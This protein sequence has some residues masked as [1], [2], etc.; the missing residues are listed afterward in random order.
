MSAERISWE[1]AVLDFRARPENAEMARACFYDD[2]LDAAARRYADSSEWKAVRAWLP[3]PPGRALD[4][5]AGRGISSHA[6]ARDGWTVTALEPDPSDVVGA[7]AIRAL[8]ERT[9]LAIRV[10]QQPA[11]SLPFE[12]ASFELVHCRAVLHHAADLRRLCADAA[13]VLVPGGRF[14]ALREH[15]ISR[16][17]DL[18][19]FLDSHPL[20]H[21]YG[22]EHAYLLDE[23]T[24][25]IQAA[26]LRLLR[27]VNPWQ[28]DAN[29]FP[30]TVEDV[31][32][33]LASRVHLPWPGLIPRAAVTWAGARLDAPGRLYSFVAEKPRG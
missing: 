12:D 29:T 17:A 22:G 16:E 27:V 1:Q 31:R 15:V 7:G 28:S 20:H 26:G 11:E 13:R 32:A 8:S 2:P 18:P 23:Y 14:V 21:L 19:A 25:A 3:D 10:I 30:Q 24:D 6:L 4:L 9:G 5:G 33:A